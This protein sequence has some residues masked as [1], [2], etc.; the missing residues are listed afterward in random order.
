MKKLYLIFGAALTLSCCQ[1]NAQEEGFPL[2]VFAGEIA[3]ISGPA[4]IISLR[5]PEDILFAVNV[6]GEQLEREVNGVTFFSDREDVNPDGEGLDGYRTDWTH[7]VTNWQNKPD[8]GDTSDDDELEEIMSDIRWTNNDQGGDT[9]VGSHFAVNRGDVYYLELLISGNH[10]ENRIWDIYVDD[11]LVVSEFDSTN[12]EAYD[13]G[14]VYAYRGEFLAK[15]DELNVTFNQER[16]DGIDGNAIL[17]AVLLS[18]AGE[19]VTLGDF[20]DD[21]VIDAADFDILAGNFGNEG[22]SFADGD[23]NFDRRINLADFL[24]FRTIFNGQST[25]AAV[26]EPTSLFSFMIGAFLL[27]ARRR[28]R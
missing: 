5:T 18:V 14:I 12:Y 25:G 20:N 4:D 22:V 26:P 27:G 2:E 24:E 19:G 8:F 6:W 15:D 9:G 16:R 13:P 10:D 7:N 11:E 3:N 17:Q 1:A 23:I 28:R 21:D